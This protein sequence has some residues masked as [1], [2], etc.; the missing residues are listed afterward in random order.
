MRDAA[1]ISDEMMSIQRAGGARSTEA[2]TDGVV[3]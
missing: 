3:V 1:G 2:L